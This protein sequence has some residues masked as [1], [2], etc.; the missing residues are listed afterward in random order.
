MP[1]L[2]GREAAMAIRNSGRADAQSLPIIALSADAFVE[3]IKLSEKAGM[4]AHVSKPVDF[5]ALRRRV[6]EIIIAK[7]AMFAADDGKGDR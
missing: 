5:D 6:G 3:D 1:R 2:N 7:K 4:D